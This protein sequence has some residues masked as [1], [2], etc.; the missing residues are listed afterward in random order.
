MKVF[1]LLLTSLLITNCGVEESSDESR[2][3]S[4]GSAVASAS[5][6]G[7][8]ESA[9]AKKVSK[10]VVYTVAGVAVVVCVAS[11]LKKNCLEAIKETPKKIIDSV[12]KPFTKKGAKETAET[13]AKE[14][15]DTAKTTGGDAPTG[16]DA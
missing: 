13:T 2:V 8:D 5:S 12:K 11:G 10:Y 14:T 7:E 15:A 16:T 1:V 4:E 3:M 9:L 6:Y